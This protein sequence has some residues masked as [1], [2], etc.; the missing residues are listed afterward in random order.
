MEHGKAHILVHPPASPTRSWS[1]FGSSHPEM[2]DQISVT[3]A[4]EVPQGTH[5]V[6][7]NCTS[8]L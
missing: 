4:G 7:L 5:Y 2:Q 1:S 3:G 8:F 6:S